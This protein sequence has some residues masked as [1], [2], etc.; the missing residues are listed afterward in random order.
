MREGVH[1]EGEVFTPPYSRVEVGVPAAL[2]SGR[3]MVLG[4]FGQDGQDVGLVEFGALL[5]EAHGALL[6]ARQQLEVRVEDA[7]R[8]RVRDLIAGQ[9]LGE[10]E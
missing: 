7:V 8:R 6:V 1:R 5:A 2:L 4:E 9:A 10:V 3:E